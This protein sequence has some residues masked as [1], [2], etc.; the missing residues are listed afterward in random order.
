MSIQVPI[1]TASTT[2]RMRPRLARGSAGAQLAAVVGAAVVLAGT[3]FVG[4]AGASGATGT[5]GATATTGVTGPTTPVTATSELISPQPGTPDAMPTTQI[6]F[7][8]APAADVHKIVVVGTRSGDHSGRLEPYS[9]HTG[10][11]F[12]PE[13]PFIPGERVKVSATVTVGGV[14]E[15]VSTSFGVAFPDVLG[16]SRPNRAKPITA[17]NVQ[18]YHSRPDLQPPAVTVTVP[19]VDTTAGDVFVSPVSGPGQPGPMILNPNGGLVW[20]HPLVAPVGAFDFN[21]QQYEGRTVLTWWQGLVVEGHGQGV[22]EIY[23]SNYTPIGTVRAGNGLYADLHE[24]QI[25]PEGTAFITA[26]EPEHWNLS[27]LGG[28][29]HGLIDDGIVQEIDIHTGLVMFEW[30]ALAHIPLS[31]TYMP[32][33]HQY[34]SVLD[35]F[36]I[37]SIDPL[38]DGDI[39]ISS[40]NTWAVYLLNGASGAVIWQ[41]GGKHSTFP[42]IPGARFAWQHDAEMLANAT[43]GLFDLSVFDNEDS[44]QEAGQSRG[45]ELELNTQTDTETILRSIPHPG[46]VILTNSQ[47]DVQQLP[48]GDVFVG[49]GDFGEESEISPTGQI[50]FELR[51]VGATNSFR[52]YRYPWTAQ[53]ARPPTFVASRVAGATTTQLYA[54]WNGATGV[55]SWTVL[56]G[57]SPKTL[58]PVGMYPSAGFE[59]AI[60]APTAARYLQVQAVGA[61]GVVLAS[62]KVAAD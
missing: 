30:H 51:L 23:N 14:S 39:L 57:S 44:P 24:F 10:G 45:L 15:P 47:G 9:T 5:T 46:R 3:V 22:D 61:A 50:T 34:Y 53:P 16:Y 26:F 17:T 38:A 7:L 36:H 21:E 13:H 25:T 19:A 11:S 60:A 52:A 59:T 32:I 27:K 54:S 35:Y 12:V 58:A 55:V 29:S 18:H 33:P 31:A 42:V 20:F 4:G 62:S 1:K 2:H 56:A 28:S 8:G 6:S 43:P 37:N 41:L 48:N 40:R 49:W